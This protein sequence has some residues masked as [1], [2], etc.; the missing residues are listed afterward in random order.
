M[1]PSKI[2]ESREYK[3]LTQKQALQTIEEFKDSNIKRIEMWQ[4]TYNETFD[5]IIEVITQSGE[6]EE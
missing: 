5:L 1:E 2:V 4:K 3:D 6:E